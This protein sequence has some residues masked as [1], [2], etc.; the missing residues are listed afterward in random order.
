[1]SLHLKISIRKPKVLEIEKVVEITKRA[2]K[3]PYRQGGPVTSFGKS[4][5]LEKFQRK[6]IYVL[7][8]IVNNE[9]VGAIRYFFP[10]Y[11]NLGY[12]T[13][14]TEEYQDFHK[15][16]MFKIIQKKNCDE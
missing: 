4:D 1:M 11:K 16:Y 3:T 13:E 8:V 12:K 5:L 7:I 9:I 15:V 2:Y 14:K 6:E 10:D